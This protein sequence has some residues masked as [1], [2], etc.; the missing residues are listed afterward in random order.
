MTRYQGTFGLPPVPQLKLRERPPVITGTIV[1][2]ALAGAPTGLDFHGYRIP[3]ANHLPSP[4][5]A[6]ALEIT[7][8]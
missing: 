4:G 8:L 2:Q 7:S 3:T 5:C 6:L 1:C